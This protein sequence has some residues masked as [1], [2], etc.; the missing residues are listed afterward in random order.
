[1]RQIFEKFNTSNNTNDLP[2]G[3]CI[4][5]RLDAGRLKLV[6]VLEDYSHAVHLSD[7]M[8]D[9]G[10]ETFVALFDGTRVFNRVFRKAKW[11]ATIQEAAAI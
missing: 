6:G 4:L 1:M 11:F 8:N 2:T 7:A 5:Q 9:D 3:A 10:K